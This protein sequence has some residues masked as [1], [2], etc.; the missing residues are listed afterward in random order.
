[1]KFKQL[2]QSSLLWILLFWC[3]FAFIYHSGW[4]IFT[5]GVVVWLSVV[6]F[7]A[8]GVFWTYVN[9]LSYNPQK[10]ERL[11]SKAVKCKPQ[12]IQPYIGLA[13][14]YARQKRWPETIAVLEQATELSNPRSGLNVKILLAI[15]YREAGNYDKAIELLI[16]L[17]GQGIK[18]LLTY[19]NLATTYYKMHRFEE[20]LEAARKARTFDLKSTQPVLL[21]GRIHFETQEFQKAKDDYE[22][23]ISHMRWPVESYYWLG[24]AELELEESEAAINHL[25]TAVERIK[26]DPESADVSVTQV[27][28]WLKKATNKLVNS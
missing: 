26:E 23:A 12:I 11:L 27:E 20:A 9:Y 24:R 28:E 6:Y 8:P 2:W 25:K 17:T 10:A 16:K 19:F 3:I 22:W 4:L 21:M 7:M 18:T 5:A 1:M 13:I 14:S 15:A